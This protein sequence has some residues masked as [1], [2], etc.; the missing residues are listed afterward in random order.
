[1]DEP[2]SPFGWI[3]VAATAVLALA[4]FFP[5]V[6]AGAASEVESVAGADIPVIGWLTGIVCI[7]ALIFTV[8]AAL[9][10]SRWLWLAA[11]FVIVFVGT[12]CAV[13]LGFL[14]V[15]DSAVVGW[16]TRALPPELESASPQLEA[17][18][19]LWFMFVLSLAAAGLSA[20]LVAG[21]TRNPQ[22]LV[23][24]IPVP[25]ERVEVLPYSAGYDPT[26]TGIHKIPN[27]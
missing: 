7:V 3:T 14:D 26:D 6:D 20:W 23:M 16:V 17:S 9:H 24:G 15:M 2:R 5:W 22:G 10:G 4:V 27:H 12:C 18:R 19:G 13:T 25:D 1:M 21:S 11:N 8:I